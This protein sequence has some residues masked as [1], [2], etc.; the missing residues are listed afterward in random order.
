MHV[1]FSKGRVLRVRCCAVLQVGVLSDNGLETTHNMRRLLD[2]QA[3]ADSKATATSKAQQIKQQQGKQQTTAAAVQLPSN[4]TTV[5]YMP[6]LSD[7]CYQLA[8]LA[9][10]PQ[11]ER[12][13]DFAA[14]AYSLLETSLGKV[15]EASGL[16]TLQQDSRTGQVAVSLTGKCGR[17]TIDP[18]VAR[19]CSDFVQQSV[20]YGSRQHVGTLR[21]HVARQHAAPSSICRASFLYAW[22]AAANVVIVGHHTISAACFVPC[23]LDSSCR[24]HVA[25][26]AA[27]GC[28][29][30]GCA[31]IQQPQQ[32]RIQRSQN[33]SNML[34]LL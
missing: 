13:S 27:A 20:K 11:S 31:P 16:Q 28:G 22:L 6:R 5:R 34:R 2:R 24:H 21:Q 32:R 19:L 3:A 1:S 18:D 15:Q 4:N 7:E 14:A 25:G 26:T 8:Q 9:R 33:C 17:E 29:N 12:S 23:R 10:L 30:L